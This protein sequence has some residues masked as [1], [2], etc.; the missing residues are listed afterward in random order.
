MSLETLVAEL[1]DKRL[2]ELGV[3]ANA[4]TLETLRIGAGYP[5]VDQLAGASGVPASTIRRYEQGRFHHL[6][7]TSFRNFSKLGALMGIDALK[8]S[9]LALA[10]KRARA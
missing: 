5:T 6:A 9:Q 10:A 7:Q 1:V 2:R 8:Y 3:T 4:E